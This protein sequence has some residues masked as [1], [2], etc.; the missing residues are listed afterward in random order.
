MVGRKETSKQLQ[1]GLESLSSSLNYI[2][3]LQSALGVFPMM[4]F[5]FIVSSRNQTSFLKTK[6][7]FNKMPL[8]NY[9]VYIFNRYQCFPFHV[10]QDRKCVHVS[11]V[12]KR[13]KT[14]LVPK[15]DLQQSTEGLGFQILEETRLQVSR[16][17]C[18]KQ[19]TFF[20]LDRNV[21]GLISQELGKDCLLL[22]PVDKKQ[23]W[24]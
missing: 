24:V 4:C 23:Q 7:N 16:T 3:C 13:E 11:G 9:H 21:I 6:H 15:K 2:Q 18:N 8:Q 22:Q 10:L 17:N 19:N 1:A 14:L 20:F 12:V 5:K